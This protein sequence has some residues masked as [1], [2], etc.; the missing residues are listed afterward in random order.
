MFNQRREVGSQVFFTDH[1]TLKTW[2]NLQE[3]KVHNGEHMLPV[4]SPRPF[5]GHGA[6]GDGD[7]QHV[8]DA[9]EEQKL[10]EREGA[11]ANQPES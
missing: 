2:S 10:C 5:Q 4:L 7:D 1:A 9:A 11:L 8:Q 3:G 6:V